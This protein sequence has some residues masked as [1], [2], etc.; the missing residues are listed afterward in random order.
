MDSPKEVA[1]W[2]KA[3]RARLIAARMAQS[4]TEREDA[5]F[6]IA[7]TLEELI[8]DPDGVVISAYW[9]FRAGPQTAA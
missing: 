7:D 6:R 3:E 8:G 1:T 4:P 2:R 9:P 5:T